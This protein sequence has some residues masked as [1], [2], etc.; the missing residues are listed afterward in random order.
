MG[1]GGGGG[2]DGLG[3]G[4]STKLEVVRSGRA[5]VGASRNGTV[6][7]SVGTMPFWRT[8]VRNVDAFWVF[9]NTRDQVAR[10]AHIEGS[11]FR[12]ARWVDV[13]T[14]GAATVTL[15]RITMTETEPFVTPTVAYVTNVR[16]SGSGL[17]NV[18]TSR[19][20]GAGETACGG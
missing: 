11:I 14:C 1:I 3:G 10:S 18:T 12:T 20:L 16:P 8:K 7:K 19:A 5:R 17:L 2:A 13:R 15:S 4:G 9:R 6:E